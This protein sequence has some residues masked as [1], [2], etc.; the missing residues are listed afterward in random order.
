MSRK[1][2]KN[3]GAIAKAIRDRHEW[4]INDYRLEKLY[5]YLYHKTCRKCGLKLCRGESVNVSCMEYNVIMV[6]ES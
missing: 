5:T 6:M 4:M 3:V 1:K 2:K